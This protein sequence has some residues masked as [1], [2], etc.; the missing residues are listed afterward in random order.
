[1][2]KQVR[3]SRQACLSSRVSRICT[4]WR[5]CSRHR[6]RLERRGPSISGQPFSIP[7]RGR[8]AGEWRSLR[9]GGFSRDL[10][11]LGCGVLWT[12]NDRG[13]FLP[14]NACDISIDRIDIS[15]TKNIDRSI[16]QVVG[17]FDPPYPT[18]VRP[19]TVRVSQTG[20]V[21]VGPPR[22]ISGRDL[23]PHRGLEE[24]SIPG[25]P[26]S[27]LGRTDVWDGY[28]C[29][30]QGN[31]GRRVPSRV[32]HPETGGEA[33]HWQGDGAVPQ[34]PRRS[35][36]RG[37]GDV[38]FHTCETF[39]RS[40]GRNTRRVVPGRRPVHVTSTCIGCT[41]IACPGVL[42]G[43]E[44]KAHSCPP[45][46]PDVLLGLRPPC[47][48]GSLPDVH[49]V[50]M[51]TLRTWDRTARHLLGRTE[52]SDLDPQRNPKRHDDVYFEDT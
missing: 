48:P 18:C 32:R 38:G 9:G 13:I 51:G 15:R 33:W 14:G 2:A 37:L 49:R 4:S 26:R 16:G 47:Q 28:T 40:F 44:R 46:D 21:R 23:P 30:A 20:S 22:W 45:N 11:G 6:E 17:G 31:P 39:F 3:T 35:N 34:P 27:N 36:E 29:G 8:G 52:P 19:L 10:P 5:R 7:R 24:T 25:E 12:V 43:E 50:R 41:S 1:M 42:V